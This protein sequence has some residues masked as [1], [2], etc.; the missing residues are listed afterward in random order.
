MGIV[1]LI[2]KINAMLISRFVY[3]KLRTNVGISLNIF[4]FFL[5]ILSLESILELASDSHDRSRHIDQ[6][7]SLAFSVFMQC[8]RLLTHNPIVKSLTG[9]GPASVYDE[10]LKPK[11]VSGK[12]S[13][14]FVL[15]YFDDS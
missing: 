1:T 5:Q 6:L 10:F 11:D 14:S 3:L 13:C 9:F 4:S 7:K 2:L 15:W 12:M 8:R